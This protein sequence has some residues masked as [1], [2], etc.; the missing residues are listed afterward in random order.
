MRKILRV[1]NRCANIERGGAAQDMRAKRQQ[2]KVFQRTIDF[3]NGLLRNV[4][5]AR[6]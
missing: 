5:A 6:L 1:G 3:L 4:S 2:R